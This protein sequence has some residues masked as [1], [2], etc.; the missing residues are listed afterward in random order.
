[1]LWQV[2]AQRKYLLC[3]EVTMFHVQNVLVDK[4]R[5]FLGIIYTILNMASGPNNR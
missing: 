2:D 4:F 3:K 5:K 1:M